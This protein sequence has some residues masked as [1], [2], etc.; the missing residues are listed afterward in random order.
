MVQRA[1]RARVSS[2]RRKVA[3]AP[4]TISRKS[5][6]ESAPSMA[7]IRITA[8]STAASAITEKTGDIQRAG[9]RVRAV[10]PSRA[11]ARA[12]R[13][14]NASRA[15]STTTCVAC[16]SNLDR[17]RKSSTGECGISEASTCSNLNFSLQA[18]AGRQTS[19]SR[20]TIT[21]TMAVS[22]Q[23]IARKSP[24]LEADCK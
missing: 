24:A 17:R 20:S 4:V 5:L 15:G 2:T 10:G 1:A 14:A 16:E 11:E 18:M 19:W 9:P 13:S 7:L 12:K 6:R 22:P 8:Y 23:A 21:A 3:P